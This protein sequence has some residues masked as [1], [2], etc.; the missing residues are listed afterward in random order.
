[1][2]PHS[3]TLLA[4]L[5]QTLDWKVLP[6][7]NTLPY[8]ER[9]YI[10]DVKSLITF[11]PGKEHFTSMCSAVINKEKKKFFFDN[12]IKT[13]FSSMTKRPLQAFQA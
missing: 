10:T 6:G 12:F 8:Y 1:M 9:S 13:F 11:G 5:L 3:G 2:L 4:L 7:T